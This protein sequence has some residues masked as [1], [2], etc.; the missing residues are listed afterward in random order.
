MQNILS[1]YS[2]VPHFKMVVI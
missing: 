1:M 2:E